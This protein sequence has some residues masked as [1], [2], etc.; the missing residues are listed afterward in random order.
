MEIPVE[1]RQAVV[2]AKEYLQSRGLS[3]GEPV[4]CRRM[5]IPPDHL[6]N[7]LARVPETSKSR[8]ADLIA[9]VPEEKKMRSHWL[10]WFRDPP[11][12][13]PGDQ[14]IATWINVFDDGMIDLKAQ[15]RL[16]AVHVFIS[17][18]RFHSD[19]ELK[20]FL[21]P[22]YDQDGNMTASVC[23]RE[24][25]LSNYEPACIESMR[26]ERPVAL[27]ELLPGFS[28]IDKWLQQVL[29]QLDD[30]PFVDAVV[31]VFSPNR[32]GNP[33]GSSLNYLGIFEFMRDRLA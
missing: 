19:E 25:E 30:P 15:V 10:L 33:Q 11:T 18:G 28:Y 17:I 24:V 4:T 29:E 31:C 6:P 8:V 32:L 26:S 9:R 20:A 2:Q 27:K 14:Y 5:E 12:A 21:D 16:E 23:M 22:T 7:L 13:R 1:A 3:I